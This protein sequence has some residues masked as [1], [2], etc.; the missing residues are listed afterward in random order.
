MD[1]LRQSRPDLVPRYEKVYQ[2]GAYAPRAERERLASM[3]R[4]G[5]KPGA[6]WRGPSSTGQSETREHARPA[7]ELQDTLF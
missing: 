5:G 4:R 2:R 1:W 7:T 3:V 6:F